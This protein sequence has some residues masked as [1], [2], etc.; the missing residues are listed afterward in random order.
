[1]STLNITKHADPTPEVTDY[2]ILW[3]C[4]RAALPE[5]PPDP[6]SNAGWGH[7]HRRNKRDAG[8]PTPDVVRTYDYLPP[9]ETHAVDVYHKLGRLWGVHYLLLPFDAVETDRL[10]LTRIVGE[11]ANRLPPTRKTLYIRNLSKKCANDADAE[12]LDEINPTSVNLRW[13]MFYWHGLFP[14]SSPNSNDRYQLANPNYV[15]QHTIPAPE[16]RDEKLS[17][18][19]RYASLGLPAN[20]AVEHFNADSPAEVR[21]VVDDHPDL[22]YDYA[23]LRAAGHRMMARTW[24]TIESWGRSYDDIATAFDRDVEVV[25]HAVSQEVERGY[26]PPPDVTELRQL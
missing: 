19:R 23:E 26:E 18:L 25:R 11:V 22:P 21:A 24:C 17:H 6:L 16:T 8:M 3:A 10:R 1:M 20:R 2:P 13:Q 4:H 5:D 14:V 12:Y 15:H 9:Y 7:Y